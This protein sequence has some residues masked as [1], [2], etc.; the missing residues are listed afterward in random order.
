MNSQIDRRFSVAPMLDCTDKHCRY[1]YRLLSKKALLYS[2]MI[3]T[4][5]LLHHDP[6]RWLIFNPQEHPLALQLGGSHP[7]EL[8]ICAKIAQDYGYDEVNLNVGCPSDRVQNARFG[9]CL[10]LEPQRV[11]ECVQVMQQAVQIP[12]TVK[13]RIGVDQR[14]SYEELAEFISCVSQAGCRTFIIHARKAWLSGLSPKQNREVPPLRYEVVF[15]LKQQFTHLEIILNGGIEQI[16]TATTLL[17]QVDGVML[18]RA[19]YQQPYLLAEVDEKIFAENQPK[20]SRQQIVFELV[21]YIQAQLANGVRLHSISRH[22]LGLFHGQKGGKQWRR[23]LSENATAVNA[24]EQIL[25]QSLQF[26]E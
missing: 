17:T 1:F 16:E 18:G 5:A 10:M 14:D 3:S 13:C 19:V 24:T 7:Q 8:A 15:Q 12:V 23:Y 22:L 2:E 26:I 25:L 4:A 11:A 9:A 6:S 20:R 21:P